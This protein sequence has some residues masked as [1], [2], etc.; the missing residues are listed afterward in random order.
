MKVL[1]FKNV[2]KLS[3][4]LVLMAIVTFTSCKKDDPVVDPPVVVLDGIYVNGDAVA[5]SDYNEKA[6]MA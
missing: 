3:S 5:Y 2:L 6:M 4:V 1:N